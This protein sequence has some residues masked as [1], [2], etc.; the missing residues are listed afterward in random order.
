VIHI[1]S[2]TER[3]KA[4]WRVLLDLAREQRHWTLI[5]ARM[6]ALHAFEHGRSVTHVTVDADALA[7]ARERPNPV[8]GLA[9]ILTGRGFTL[10]EPNAFGEAHTFTRE[11]VEIDVLAPDHLGARADDARTTIPP[12]HTVAVPGGRQALARSESVTIEL[13]GMEGDLPRPDLLGAIL[14][15]ARAVDLGRAAVHRGDL[16]LLLSL[17]EDP[18]HLATAL[19][20]GEAAWLR[21]RA[22]ME[23]P[24]ADCWVALPRDA[25]IRG[26]AALRILR[27]G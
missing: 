11:G 1:P 17:V 7:D 6:V 27:D 26:V 25:R 16:A 15:K 8:R 22:E 21:E 2:P 12:A 10:V 24:S 3:E 13:D 19:R 20:G 14:L 23:D 5:G 9:Q 4:M 18:D